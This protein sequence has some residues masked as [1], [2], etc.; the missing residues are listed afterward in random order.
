MV[1]GEVQSVAKL[2]TLRSHRNFVWL[3][4]FVSTLVFSGFA[5]TYFLHRW[6]GTP[7]LSRFMHVHAVVMTSWIALFLVQTL[8]ISARRVSIHRSLGFI[9]IA[10]AFLVVTFGVSATVMSAHR[11]VAANSK[12][13]PTFLVVLAL[14]LTQMAMFAGF[15]TAGFCLRNRVD[16]H[17]RFMLLGTFCMLPNPIVRIVRLQSFI[18]PLTIWSV[19]IVLVALV[20]RRT[21]GEMHPVFG[22]WAGVEIAVLWLAYFVGI[23][24]GWQSL[25]RT[26]V[27]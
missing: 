2:R 25:A 27:S 24:P 15:L 3:S 8:L 7:D 13:A 23:S 18:A 19:L 12:E 10:C 22:R 1:K 16:Y 26:V 6:F 11:E 14:E 17:K 21:S 5:R 20:D 4:I 9:G